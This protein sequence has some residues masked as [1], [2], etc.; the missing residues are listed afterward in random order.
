MLCFN[1]YL[2]QLYIIPKLHNVIL[3]FHTAI[4]KP[5]WNQYGVLDRQSQIFFSETREVEDVET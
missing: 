5:L 2:R 3:V 4:I 1:V